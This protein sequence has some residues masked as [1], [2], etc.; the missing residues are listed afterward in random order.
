[1]SLKNFG[2]HSDYCPMYKFF[3]LGYLQPVRGHV[4]RSEGAERQGQAG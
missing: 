4:H 2:Y 1:M 3:V